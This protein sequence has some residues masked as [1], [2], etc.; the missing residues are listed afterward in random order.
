MEDQHT[1]SS[2]GASGQPGSSLLVP[3]SGALFFVFAAFA[4]LKNFQ[5]WSQVEDLFSS[6]RNPFDT[7]DNFHFYRY[8]ATYP[9]LLMEEALPGLGFTLFIA[10]FIFVA[11]YFLQKIHVRLYGHAPH[12]VVW[13]MFLA[14]YLFMNGRGAIAWA[15]W[16]V[17]IYLVVAGKDLLR[18]P[19]WRVALVPTVLGILLFSSVSTGTFIVALC[20]I[21]LLVVKVFPRRLVIPTHA[22]ILPI[23][24]VLFGLVLVLGGLVA[25]LRYADAGIVKLLDYYGSASNV[26]EHGIGSVL[27]SVNLPFLI[28]GL[29][30]AVLL[31]TMFV[32]AVGRR[33]SGTIW[34]LLGISAGCG[35]FGYTTLTMV[36]PV[37]LL[38]V[39][40]IRINGL[41]VLPDLRWNR[42]RARQT[43]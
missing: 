19:T 10:G 22:G 14:P 17:C 6:Y 25:A 26:F 7:A 32:I 2:S 43:P 1:E 16:I 38:T 40:A 21:L 15:A 20:G 12:A 18:D 23:V 37:V 24:S 33:V 3:V 35:L 39:A 8:L 13:A 28:A 4:G 42:P 11:A 34:L 27:A 36:I 41:P 5:S 31:M 30:L 9:G 29:G